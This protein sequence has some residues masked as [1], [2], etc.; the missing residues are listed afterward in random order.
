MKR[1]DQS[2]RIGSADAEILLFNKGGRDFR[3]ER[4]LRGEEVPREFFYGYFDLKDAGYSTA[5]MSTSGAVP[6]LAG[7]VAD[8]VE[9]GFASLTQLG[10]RPLSMRVVA[11]WLARAR[12]AISYTD[13]FSLSMGLGFPRSDARP[14]LI[15]G[16]HGLSD[17]ETRSPKPLRSFVRRVIR[18]ALA[19]LDHAFF[20]GPADRAFAIE[21]YGM[22]SDRSSI[23]R[24]GI[25]TDFW[26]P[27][28]DVSPNDFVVAIGQDHN[29]DYD[30]LAAAPG[31]HPTRIVTHQ[32]VTIPVG[33]D[34]VRTTI[35]DFFNADSMSDEDIRRLYNTACAVIVPLKDVY[36]PSGYSVTLQA[37]SCGRPVILSNNRGLWA[38]DLLRNGE[39]C[40]LVPPGDAAALGAAIGRIRSD[41]GLAQRLGRAGRETVTRHFGLNSMGEATI[42]LAKL[43][44]SIG[45]DAAERAA[46]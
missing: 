31:R 34:H 29:R 42:R 24:F 27:M 4:L 9:R 17:I 43:G 18:R 2:S 19:G 3:L 41:A 20:F 33:A 32:R 13:G 14:A 35:G 25:D 6:G 36:Q 12:V 5:M 8:A 15:G 23:F 16:F 38:P 46:A 37:L 1:M 21:H 28:P 45:L 44:L 30:L 10:V 40:L 7:W 26:R 39:N 11:P 22:S